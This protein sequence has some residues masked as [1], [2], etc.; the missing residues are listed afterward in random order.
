M[1]I[2]AISD[3]H[4]AMELLDSFK[5]EV[6]LLKPDIIVFTGDIVKGYARCNEFLEAMSWS[7]EP[8]WD[9]PEIEAE[10]ME[11]LQIYSEFFGTIETLKIPT[12]IIPGNMDAP[13]SRF[14][15]QAFKFS[16]SS[17]YIKILQENIIII[18]DYVLFGFGGEI[19]EA[20]TERLFVLQY[21]KR[22][23][24]FAIRKVGYIE[25]ESIFL[26][27]TPPTGKIVDIEAGSHRGSLRINEFIQRYSPKIVFCG[28]AH[29]AQ[30]MEMIDSS[31]VINPGAMKH[32]NMSIVD[33]KTLEVEFKKIGG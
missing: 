30:G 28:H 13:E 18:E 3:L 4:G 32:G 7:R 19:T 17:E 23:V 24:E 12:M 11:D 21:P 20:S 25:K 9:K 27:H 2:L 26:F 16:I 22:Q 33:T 6:E 1:K 14:F 15:S 5:Q 8:V 10:E 29:K 31:L